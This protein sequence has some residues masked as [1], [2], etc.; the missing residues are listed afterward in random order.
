[1]VGVTSN[2]SCSTFT[3]T[4]TELNPVYGASGEY[5]P[6][7]VIFLDVSLDNTAV[8]VTPNITTPWAIF[9]GNIFPSIA[10][11]TALTVTFE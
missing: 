11:V 4:T 7:V 9:A 1:M 3:S 10:D 8:P 6:L 2:A 5:V